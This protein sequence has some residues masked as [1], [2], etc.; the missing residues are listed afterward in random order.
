MY[1]YKKTTNNSDESFIINGVPFSLQECDNTEAALVEKSLEELWY[2]RMYAYSEEEDGGWSG[3]KS[4]HSVYWNI[5]AE[6]AVIDSG[7]VIGFR[8]KDEKC[9][10]EVCEMFFSIEE[11]GKYYPINRVRY[12]SFDGGDGD[13]V[14]TYSF[15]LEKKDKKIVDFINT[16]CV[17]REW[18][19]YANKGE[20]SFE[21]IE[22]DYDSVFVNTEGNVIA[23]IGGEFLR[24]EDEGKVIW[25]GGHNHT[26]FTL[27][28][29]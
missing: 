2:I 6:N 20:R 12:Y 17:Y 28:R 19:H 14:T 10:R 9:D 13:G 25:L 16:F 8:I 4:S 21:Y 11:A 18:D 15:A 24:A 27:K 3:T 23:N 5:K 29:K 26:T 7:K 1:C 22:I